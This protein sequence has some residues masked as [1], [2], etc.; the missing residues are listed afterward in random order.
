[1]LLAVACAILQ[2]LLLTRFQHAV[3][4]FSVLVRL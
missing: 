4:G 2:L 1:M 3:L